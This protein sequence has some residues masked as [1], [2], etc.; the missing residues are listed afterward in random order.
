MKL[1]F[2]LSAVIALSACKDH[3]AC[4][5]KHYE[6]SGFMQP[7][8]LMTCNGSSCQQKF[9]GMAWFDTSGNVCDRWQYPNGK[10]EK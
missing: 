8:Y 1:L 9:I 2:L 5:Q 10:P 3:G 7:Q 6:F 4:L